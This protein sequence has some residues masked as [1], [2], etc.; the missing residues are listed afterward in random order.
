MFRRAFM[1]QFKVRKNAA[2]S[3]YLGSIS[4]NY[5][6]VTR[7]DRVFLRVLIYGIATLTMINATNDF[8]IFYEMF[9]HLTPPVH[10]TY[11]ESDVP[12]YI[13]DQNDPIIENWKK[14]H[15]ARKLL[16]TYDI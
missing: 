4:S 5:A 7:F 6:I 12:K 16:K 8:E 14:V 3:A 1:E 11:Y 2:P 15:E 9:Y 10:K 13:R